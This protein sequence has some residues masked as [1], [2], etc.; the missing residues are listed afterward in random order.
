MSG[1]AQVVIDPNDPR[2]PS[3]EVWDSLSEEERAR[4]VESLPSEFPSAAP[5]EGDPH[6]FAALRPLEA[7][8][9]YFRRIGKKVYVS[10]NLPV[11]YPGERMFAP[12]LIAVLDVEPHERERWVV[13][14]EGKGLDLALEVMYRGDDR[15]DLEENVQR[16][17]RLGIE[18]YFIFDRKRG[19]LVGYRLGPERRYQLI[20]PQQGRWYSSVLELDLMLEP[21]R[22]RFYH[23]SAPLPELAELAARA[24]AMLSVV[25]TEKEEALRRAEQ[26]A[27]RAEREAL[28]ADEAERRFTELEAELDRLRRER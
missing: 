21:G 17:A 5:P 11:Y 1:I 8:S 2:A 18:E 28:R 4:V 10:S 20:V 27:L 12:D 15:K 19:S 7:L 13:S 24:E 23:G 9:E 3:Q 14:A 26:E 6:R 16:Y 22:L 25:M